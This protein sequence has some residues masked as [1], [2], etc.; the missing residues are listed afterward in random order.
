MNSHHQVLPTTIWYGERGIVNS[1][2]AHIS[3]QPDAGRA[4]GRLLDAVQWANAGKP[5]WIA[6]I[7][8]ANLVVEIGLADF[9][10]PDLMVVCRAEGD[11]KPYCVFIEAKAKCYQFSTGSNSGGMSPGFN[12]TIN[13]QISLKYRFATALANPDSNETEIVEPEPIYRAYKEQLRDY[14]RN[15]RHLKKPEILQM[16]GDLGLISLPET[17]CYYV[18]LTWDDPTHAFTTDPHLTAD[19]LPRFLSEDGGDV[20][21]SAKP[22]LGWLGYQNLERALGLSNSAEY[23]Q[24]CRGMFSQSEPTPADYERL[25]RRSGLPEYDEDFLQDIFTRFRQACGQSKKFFHRQ[26]TGSYSLV[27]RKT[28]A[29]MIPEGDYIFVG[30]RDDIQTDSGFPSFPRAKTVGSV[31]FHGTYLKPD[32]ESIDMD[33]HMEGILRV[34]SEMAASI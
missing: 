9:G 4:A 30:V 15:P 24:A 6:R 1:T 2:V 27:V 8:R 33:S 10:N 31:T 32:C 22:R 23:R 20:Y 25:S 11:D 19:N 29:K 21:E 28:L 17:R 3:R 26:N 14:S 34:F 12:S 16:F 5:D 13:G 18:A 7:D